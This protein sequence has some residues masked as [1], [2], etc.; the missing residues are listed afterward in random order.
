MDSERYVYIYTHVRLW[1]H[2]HCS[3]YLNHYVRCVES[4]YIV[5]VLS[6]NQSKRPHDCYGLT[7]EK[8]K[9][10]KVKAWK[11]LQDGYMVREGKKGNDSK[12]EHQQY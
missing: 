2:K 6:Y 7:I 5:F 9:E 12:L 10:T 11:C 3:F 4:N 1:K 8:E